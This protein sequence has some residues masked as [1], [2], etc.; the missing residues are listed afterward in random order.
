[1]KGELWQVT[2]WLLKGLL[3]VTYV[4]ITPTSGAKTNH[5]AIPG[6]WACKCVPEGTESEGAA[7][8]AGNPVG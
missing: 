8:A 1:M 6:V 2:H 5:M 7:E 3:A 4:I